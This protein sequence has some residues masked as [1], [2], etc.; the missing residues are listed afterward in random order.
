[1]L[2]TGSDQPSLVQGGALFFLTAVENWQLSAYGSRQLMLLVARTWQ[3][4]LLL[5]LLLATG[6]HQ[7]PLLMLLVV[8]TWQQLLLL[9]L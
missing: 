9:L 1:M 5:L 8:R 4:L 7:L 6:G 3:Q 2:H